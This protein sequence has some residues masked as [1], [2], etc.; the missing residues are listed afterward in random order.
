MVVLK[1]ITFTPNDYWDVE[2]LSYMSYSVLYIP[3]QNTHATTN[4]LTLDAQDA[5]QKHVCLS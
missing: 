1:F 2:Y 3:V 5:K 4:H